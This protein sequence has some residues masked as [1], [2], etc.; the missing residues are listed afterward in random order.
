MKVA[1]KVFKWIA[2]LV[3][4]LIVVIGFSWWLIPDEALDAEAEKF[5]TNRKSVV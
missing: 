5:T 3:L 2:G 1:L 4:A